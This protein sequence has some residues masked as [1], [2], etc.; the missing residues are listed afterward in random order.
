MTT[1]PSQKEDRSRHYQAWSAPGCGACRNA[2]NR[3]SLNT[4]QECVASTAPNWKVSAEL[5]R[6]SSSPQSTCSALQHSK[7]Q[8][9]AWNPE[10]RPLS[11]RVGQLINRWSEKETHDPCAQTLL[12]TGA[13][14]CPAES[15]TGSHQCN[16]LQCSPVH[17]SGRLRPTPLIE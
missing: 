8:G 13:P 10:F 16:S 14:D 17:G 5:F 6:V 12:L 11:L 3:V 2:G 7:N 9:S 4:T 15:A 1:V